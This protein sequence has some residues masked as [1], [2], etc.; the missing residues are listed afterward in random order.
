MHPGLVTLLAE[1][2]MIKA[3]ALTAPVQSVPA[4]TV[5]QRKPHQWC[6]FW[7]RQRSRPRIGLLLEEKEK[8][9]GTIGI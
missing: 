3:T 8:R 1:A 7:H 2:R 5:L 9:V 4:R 6:S